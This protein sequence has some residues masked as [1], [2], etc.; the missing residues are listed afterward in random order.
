LFGTA[1]K[2][3]VSA[4]KSVT[5]FNRAMAALLVLSLIPVFLEG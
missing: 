3:V 5:I 2:R 1:L 4:P